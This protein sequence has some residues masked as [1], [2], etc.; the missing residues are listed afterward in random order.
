MSQPNP[1]QIHP[2]GSSY[3]IHN[4]G[5]PD[6][7]RQ[8]KNTTNVGL[9]FQSTPGP[10]ILHLAAGDFVYPHALSEDVNQYSDKTHPKLPA[11]VGEQLTVYLPAAM[12]F[13]RVVVINARNLMKKNTDYQWI[14]DVAGPIMES[15]AT[16]LVAGVD[17]YQPSMQWVVANEQTIS[18]LGFSKVSPAAGGAIEQ[19]ELVIRRLPGGTF[20][21]F[22]GG[23]AMYSN[24]NA[25]QVIWRK[26]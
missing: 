5:E 17:R 2:I 7:D 8:S 18:N 13:D 24:A 26:S 11:N 6:Q 1:G 12:K 25:V 14:F 19:A 9:Y 21:G 20:G 23:M 10:K 4:Y 3:E 15:G 22:L 16:I